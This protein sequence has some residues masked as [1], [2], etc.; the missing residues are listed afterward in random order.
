MVTANIE[1]RRV[2]LV[3]A[4]TII[5]TS[6]LLWSGA[7]WS[8]AVDGISFQKSLLQNETSDTPTSLQ[9][10][11][12]G[13]LYVAQQDGAI[14][15]YTVARNG[16]NS[17]AVTATQTIDSVKLIPNHND[18]GTLDSVKRDKRQVTGL[19]VTGTASNPVIYVSSS[20]PRIGA[21]PNGKGDVNLDTNSGIISRLTWNGSAWIKVDLVRGLPRSEE[22]HSPNGM[23]LDEATN[24]LYLA[25][26]GN[27]NHGA[28]SVNF[29]LLPE[30]ALSGAILSIDLNAI[31]NPPYDLPTLNDEDRSGNPDAND[32]FGGNDGKNQARLVAGGP[33]Q[34]YSPGFRNPYDVLITQSGT[35]Y[36]IDN[37]G[38]A[39]WGDVP[40]NEGPGGVC[41][42]DPKEPGTTDADTLH[43]VSGPGYYGGHPNPTRGNLNNKFNASKPQSPVP[44][45]NPIECDYRAP[46]VEK[47]D[48][49]SFDESTNGLTQYTASNLGGAM[50]G[51]LLAAGYNNNDIYRIT[52]NSAGDAIVAKEVLFSTVGIHPLDVIAQGDGG[53]FPGTIWVA[54]VANGNI[55][56]FEPGDGSGGTCTGAD[57]P[58]QDEDGDGFDNADEIDNDT[59][60]CSPADFPSDNEGD[61]ISDLNDPDD[62]NDSLPD[63]SDP[64]AVDKD[65]GKTT[66]LPV[67]YTWDNDAPAPGGLLSLGFTGL[68]TNK[69]SNYLSLYDPANM[70]AGGAAGAVTVDKVPSGD[71]NKATNTQKYGFHFGVNATAN[72]GKFT[73]HTR[74]LAP[75]AGM[76]PQD[77]QSMGLFIG[78]GDQDNYVKLVTNANGGAGGIKFAKEVG[79][80]IAGP[81]MVPVSMPGPDAVDLYLTVDPAANTVQPSYSVT[82]NGV[83][84]PRNNVGA[85]MSIP[86]GWFGGTTG[87]AV[88]IISTSAGPGP[89]FPATWDFIEV[90]PEVSQNP[91]GQW[92]SLAPNSKK[93]QEVAYVQTGG[94]FYLAGGSTV[95]ERYDPVTNTWEQ[96][97]PLPTK[98]DHIQGVKLGGKIYYIGGLAAWPRPDV[99]TVYVYDPATDTFSEGAPMPE[100]RSR[101][102]GGVAV[103]NGKIYYA[104]GLH[105]GRA[106][107]WF[108]VYDPATEIWTQLPNMPRVRD[109]F[110]AAVVDGKFYAIGGRDSVVSAMTTKVDVY[111]LASGSA[112]TWQ[113][114]NTELPTPRGGFATAVLG[115]EIL[116]IGGEGGGKAHNEVEAYDTLNNSWRALK[117]M[118]TAR[119]G[120]QAA[121]CNGGVYIAAGGLTQGAFD[122]TNVHEAFFLNGTTA[123]ES[124]P[125]DTLPPVVKPPAQSLVTNP[126]LGTVEVPVKLSWSGTD[127][128][129]GISHYEL[130]Q[131]I[132]GGPYT[133]VPL[134]SATATTKTPSLEPGK[135]YRFQVRAQDQAGNWSGWK[136]GPSFTVNV[137]QESDSS[138]GYVGAWSTESLSSAYGGSLK[139]AS[140]GGKSAKLTFSGSSVA[141]VASK[142]KDR[143][144][145]EV[146]MDGTKINNTDLYSSTVQWRKV[147]FA[148]NQLSA[149][150]PH[151]IEVRTLGTKNASSSGTRVDVDAFVVL[152]LP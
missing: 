61:K 85:P 39:G 38:N 5:A 75:F 42:N 30:Y 84:G 146:W 150:Q 151:T 23:Q 152:S 70:T 20:D 56:V 98:L 135:T 18:D 82:T 69:S 87:L 49:T 145:A 53:P 15:V 68:M 3:L 100:G 65:N 22:N 47:G 36:T 19:V 137:L 104:G 28:P 110:H 14:K 63:T 52:L 140:A 76:T 81:P 86:A 99:G 147:V 96:V 111:S 34:V 121:V 2:L 106:V 125:G 91:S 66:N 78:N 40:V 107:P 1:L 27:T 57:D 126:T 31:G 80:T 51:D 127:S 134:S 32:P 10:G 59:N 108:D 148:K 105:D 41:T 113:T 77:N 71:A 94:R 67:N 33:V 44:T 55:I 11:P 46:G 21:G 142:A 17:Y 149:L 139:H 118:P 90:T 62:D 128:A 6:L 58:T 103:H 9:F 29:A 13:R 131:S 109:H 25:Q 24:T 119:H 89:E 95:H 83:A 60:P 16:A 130:Q 143:G 64:F 93:R 129:S 74:I 141:W 79:G 116:V 120:I 7:S 112:G 115:K 136:Q 72:T 50:Q 132:G 123:C 133:S 101:G 45:A 88:G 144:I 114:P 12:D 92:Q 73:A 26:G 138:I 117:P 35:M 122:P 48:L 4:S 43:L 124:P 8:W 97:E 54:D 37:G 102:A